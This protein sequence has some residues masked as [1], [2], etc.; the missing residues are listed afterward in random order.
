M[1]DEK[2]NEINNMWKLAVLETIAEMLG[3]DG[4]REKIKRLTM[5]KEEIKKLLETHV[6]IPRSVIKE[7]NRIISELYP[8]GEE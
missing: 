4:T 1:E 2:K 8:E 5:V 3:N 7:Y 6:P